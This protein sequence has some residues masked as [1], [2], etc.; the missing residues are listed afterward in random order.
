MGALLIVSLL[1]YKKLINIKRSERRAI[2][3]YSTFLLDKGK[4]LSDTLLIHGGGSG[5]RT[6][7]RI[8]YKF[9]K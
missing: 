5:N 6:R 8:S 4:Y 2:S 9:S 1:Y 7:G 3:L